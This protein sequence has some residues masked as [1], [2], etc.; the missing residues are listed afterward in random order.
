MEKR[1]AAVLCLICLLCLPASVFGDAALDS[2]RIEQVSERMPDMQVYL[3]GQQKNGLSKEEL[4]AFLDGEELQVK[5]LED[6][7]GSGEK[8]TYY[9]MMDISSSI[10]P[11][12]FESCKAALLTFFSQ[13]GAEEECRLLTFGNTVQLV[14]SGQES[15]EQRKAAVQ[16]LRAEDENTQL[17]E[18]VHQA[19]KLA[20]QENTGALGRKVGI[21]LTDGWD[22]SY[23]KATSNEA[24]EELKNANLP[25][26]GIAM[27]QAPQDKVNQFGEFVRAS[28]GE[29]SMASSGN[30]GEKLMQL[31]ESLYQGKI[32]S[33]QADTNQAAQGVETLTVKG[34]Q[35][36]QMMSAEVGIYQWV[37]DEEPP[38]IEKAEQTE[39]NQ[40]EITFSEKMAGLQKPGSYI[41]KD[42]EGKTVVPKAASS[43]DGR[44]VLL[45]FEQTLYS[46]TYEVE[47]KNLTD[48]SME[49]NPLKGTAK[50]KIKGEKKSPVAAFFRS[51]G[52][53]LVLAAV[54]ILVL[55]LTLVYRKIKKNR[56][57]LVVDD[58]MALASKVEVQQH[59][60]VEEEEGPILHL[61]L[62][63]ENHK[64]VE[65]K[66]RLTSS[67]IVGRSQM[68][69]VQV[70]D[71]RMSRQHFALELSEGR[72]W[73][74]DLDTTNGT[75][76]NGVKLQGK[77][78]LHSQDTICAGNMEIRVEWEE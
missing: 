64:T 57:I 27:E 59:V 3:M 1:I 25:V 67:L 2:M 78:Q 66:R 42:K 39:K 17:F 70:E 58:K 23:G 68:C 24:L 30:V 31:R 34:S 8:L 65:L 56:G 60:A 51:W 20:R 26:Y 54:L 74:M 7:S 46:G 75:S 44:S 4:S 48:Q 10:S 35:A 77:T 9:F 47:C 61:Y 55:V 21:V 72:I 62:K 40:V 28:Y 52:P 22:D 13:L 38:E 6:F 49:K 37:P 36:S 15:G 50:V 19:A 14:L 32:L 11:E 33:L 45:T 18:A 12:Y 16:G 69:E 71:S 29:L 73:V 63:S 41:F 76:V 53:L 43:A 5:N